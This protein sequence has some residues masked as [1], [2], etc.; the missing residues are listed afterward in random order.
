MGASREPFDFLVVIP[1]FRRPRLLS[2]AIESALGQ[3]GS[4]KI[5]VVVDDCP[6][7]SAR[8]V[9]RDF[10]D[11]GVVY[12][13]NPHPT[14]G[15][16]GEVR[17]FGF[18][19]SRQM[20]LGARFVHFLDDDDTVP[21]G[22]YRRVNQAFAERPDEGVVFGAIESLCELSPDPVQRK[23]QQA[24]FACDQKWRAN[25]AR[26]ARAYEAL[27]SA[28]KAPRLTQW[29]FAVHA[30]CGPELFLCSGGFIRYELAV[31]LGGFDPA[32]RLMEDYEFY[33]RAIRSSGAHFL[34]EVTSLYRFGG[35]DSL[36]G[37]QGLDLRAERVR[38]DEIAR[39][40]QSRKE[41]IRA[42]V[43]YLAFLVRTVAWRLAIG[44]LAYRLHLVGALARWVSSRRPHQPA[45]RVAQRAVLGR[46]G[47]GEVIGG[48]S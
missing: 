2:V 26:V 18:E 30:T 22:C 43:G 14:G 7:G 24:S 45:E 44:P 37:P 21:D 35:P 31:R 47:I 32:F 48:I 16:P 6:D 12:L 4:T 10:A 46:G 27:G 9:V 36:W 28:L 23:A 13:R 20:G 29:L 41:A 8:S 38:A 5:V 39:T 1:T 34:D 33:T 25:A 3:V 40:L 17:N 11:A 19:A 42:E 15:W